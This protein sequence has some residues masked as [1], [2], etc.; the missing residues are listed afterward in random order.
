MNANII[1]PILIALLVITSCTVLSAQQTKTTTAVTQSNESDS[2]QTRAELH[3]V[4]NRLPPEVGKVLKLDPTLWTNQNY[5]GTYPALASF[6]AQHPEVAHSPNFYLES[7]WVPGD[8][9]VESSTMR[10]A[11]DMMEGTMAFF[12]VLAAIFTLA[13]LIRTLV[14]QRRWTRLSRTQTEVHNKLLDRFSTNEELLAYIQTPVGKRFLESAPIPL[15]ANRPLAAP[16]N[17]I[18]WSVQVGCILGAAGIGLQFISN[19]V[20]KEAAEPLSA[21]GIFAIS[22][23]LGFIVSAA[24]SYILSRRFGLWQPPAT[25]TETAE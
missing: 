17:R 9:P 15:E 12:A 6:V 3:E 24:A 20:Q 22:I 11:R 13:W 1:R 18:L 10:F 8:G 2:N 14:E 16:V 5:V 19:S 21:L 23:G 25:A 7:V 4:L